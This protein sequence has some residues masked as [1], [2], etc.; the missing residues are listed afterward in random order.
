LEVTIGR[1]L[2]DLAYALQFEGTEQS[3]LRHIWAVWAPPKCKFFMWLLLQRRIF[4]ADRLLRFDM[5]NQ[6]LC[7][8]CR[9]NLETLAHMFTECPWLRQAWERTA[10]TF[11]YPAIASP[12]VNDLALA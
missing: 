12:A 6:Y 4:T 2:R 9:R 8:L 3:S 5:P 10:H 11:S 1:L 7:P